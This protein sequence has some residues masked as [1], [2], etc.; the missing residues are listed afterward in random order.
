MDPVAEAHLFAAARAEL[1]RRV[2][3][4]A[5]ARAA[6]VVLDRFVDS[7]LAYQGAGRRLG[8]DRVLALNAEALAGRLPDRALV[9]DVPPELARARRCAAPD[10]IEAEGEGFQDRVAA[11]YRELAGRFPGRVVLV[12]GEGSREE[13]HARALAAVEPLL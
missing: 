7:S 8:I 9:I 1:V 13:V 10:R 2:I 6:W 12:P 4:P 5:L 3:E 11:G